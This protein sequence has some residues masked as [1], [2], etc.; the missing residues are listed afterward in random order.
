MA[1]PYTV[2]L[3]FDLPTQGLAYR[4]GFIVLRSIHEVLSG[5]RTGRWYPAPGNLAYDKQTPREKRADNYYI[6]FTGASS[7]KEVVGAA[8]RASAPGEP[9][10]ART[11]RLR[12]SFHMMIIPIEDGYRCR[13]WTNVV[14]A[15][16]LEYG[17]EKVAPRPF[18]EPA[19]ER[20]RGQIDKEIDVYF[21]R[22]I[23][24]R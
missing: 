13:I 5:P 24:R 22:L 21:R 8:H 3:E 6:K 11:G 7:R 12:Q 23:G 2:A 9:P 16:D 14:Y 15:D 1:D 17:T 10:A 19:V 4:V 20:A 18:L